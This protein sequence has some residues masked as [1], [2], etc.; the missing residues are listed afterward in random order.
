[1]TELLWMTG[2]A[3]LIALI[4]TP[5]IRDIFRSYNIVD[6]PAQR[7]VHAYPIP[8]VGGIPIA[9]AYGLTLIGHGGGVGPW[10]AYS[11][12]ALKLIPGAALVFLI[13]LID[14]FFTLRPRQKLA[15]LVV[16]ASVAYWSGVRIEN[17]LGT[18]LAPWAGFPLTVF[19]LLLTSNALNLIDGL[20]GLCAGMGLFATLTLFAASLL[21]G[22]HPLSFVTLPLAG[23]LL[24]FLCYNLNPATVFLG[25]SGALLIGFLLGC[26]GIIWSQKGSTL[27][28]MLVPMLA[29]SIPLL[30]VSLS[31]MRRFLRNKP[32]FTADRGHIH[33]RLLDRGLSARQ[34]MWV[35]YLFATIAAGFALLATSPGIRKYQALVGAAFCAAVIFGVRQLRYS[36]FDI[37]GRLLFRGEFYR[38]VDTRIRLN[39]LESVLEKTASEEAWWK[40][41]VEGAQHLGLVSIQW[42]GK[43]PLR[44]HV[45]QPGAHQLWAFEFPL[46]ETESVRL[47]GDSPPDGTPLDLAGFAAAVRRTFPRKPVPMAAAGSERTTIV[48]PTVAAP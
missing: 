43:G 40:A 38:A 24:G 9:V 26:Y 36:E 45:L 6:R 1:M 42:T 4:L 22:N 21:H 28:S 5:I 2:T 32:I 35:L 34:A 20:D 12:A 14:D 48:T 8:R 17:M 18:E 23:A 29:M 46:G 37:A 39:Q 41:L 15:G 27:V 19:W 25:D 31:I 13:G 30:D 16:A 47:E 3:F 7:K 11:P 44:R 10:S 33:H